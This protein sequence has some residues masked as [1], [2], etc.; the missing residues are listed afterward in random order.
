LP[1][2]RIDVKRSGIHAINWF[3]AG[4]PTHVRNE[5]NDAYRDSLLPQPPLALPSD[6]EC[7]VELGPAGKG[8]VVRI[9]AL[10]SL[11]GRLEQV[12]DN[13]GTAWFDL[14][15]PGRFRVE[16]DARVVEVQIAGRGARST[17]PGFAEIPRVTLSPDRETQP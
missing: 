5:V 11:G 9:S 2:T 6:A 8:R 14:P 1:A 4:R 17:R 16:C 12:A 10:D 3:D 7:L 13:A 15:R